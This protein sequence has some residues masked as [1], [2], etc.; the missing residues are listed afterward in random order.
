MSLLSEYNRPFY[1]TTAFRLIILLAFLQLII[2]L[3]TNTLTFTHEESMWHYIGRNWFRHG[4]TP[5]QGGIDNKSPFLFAIFG[6]SDWL[7]GIN[8]W[9][10]RVIGIIV[11]SIGIYYIYRIA[12]RYATEKNASNNQ[13]AEHAG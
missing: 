6:L 1:K 12:Y 11:Q 2:A 10:P 9:F 7:F 13:H 3:F 8:Y 5:Y 4:L